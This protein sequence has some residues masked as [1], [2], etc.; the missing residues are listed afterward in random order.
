M[1]NEKHEKGCLCSYCQDLKDHG[2]GSFGFWSP[3]N[4]SWNSWRILWF[5]GENFN[6]YLRW[7]SP[8]TKLFQ[9]EG[10]YEHNR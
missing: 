1:L 8:F 6:Y 2:K 7:T 5:V 3:I 9:K 10:T 4:K